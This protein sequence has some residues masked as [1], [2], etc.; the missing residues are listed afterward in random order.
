MDEN[1]KLPIKVVPPLETD[2]HVPPL[3]GGPKKIFVEDL[4]SLQKE[5]LNQLD[6]VN[7]FFVNSFKRKPKLPAVMKVRL[8]SDAAAKSHRPTKLFSNDSCPIIG[9]EGLGGLL[10]S[11][12][13]KSLE[14]LHQKVY[15]LDTK[16]LQANLSTIEQISPF[17]PDIMLE[18]G[19]TAIKVKLIRH[20]IK[21]FDHAIQEDFLQTI[22]E[23]GLRN[24]REVN[25]GPS[26]KIFKIFEPRQELLKELSG[27][28]GTQSLSG[29]PVYY[30]VRTQALPVGKI[31]AND[32]PIPDPLV[33]YPIVGV[34]DS[35]IQNTIEVLDPWVVGKE[36]Y[37]PD[38]Y[39]NYDH[40]TFVAGLI[41]HSQRLNHQDPRFPSCSAK[42]LDVAVMPKDGISEDELLTILEDVLPRHP[43][44]KFWNLSLGTNIPISQ[45]NFSDFAVGIDRLQREYGVT[46]ILAAGNHTKYLGRGITNDTLCA[47]ADSVRSI[48]VSAV[49]HTSH[50]SSL[51]ASEQPSPFS[52]KG[53]GP[54]YL[55]KPDISHYGGNCDAQGAYLQTGVISVN[56]HG[57]LAEDIGTSF[58]APLVSTLAANISNAIVGGASKNLTK[59]LLVHSAAMRSEINTPELLHTRGF[60]TPPDLDEILECKP[61]NCTMIFEI[62]VKPRIEYRKLQFPIAP[63]LYLSNGRMKADILMTLVYDPE[64]DASFGS[65]YCRTNI[66][67]SLGVIRKN[68]DGSFSHHKEV[69]EDPKLRG[70][71]YEKDLVKGGFKWSPVKVYRR[72]IARGIQ[73]DHWQLILNTMDRG[74]HHTLSPQDA[75]LI[76]TIADPDMRAPVY[77]ETVALMSR[78]GWGAQNLA[79][80]QRL[81]F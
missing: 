20:R 60:G 37:V 56:A 32:Y 43:E 57:L 25:Y 1:T 27:F 39:A 15:R 4:E 10:V 33:E 64:L 40:G 44:V 13:P 59:A 45:N 2:Y 12:T 46:F 9:S 65:E 17:K 66:E 53:P 78:L 54:V 69:P 3:G 72:K 7:Q 75:A 63:S 50:S 47:P 21:D 42:I 16:E 18:Q 49:A 52:R 41:V 71:A 77:N 8:R 81:R 68:K 55:P 19:L 70:S 73:A 61:W 36:N 35:G 24:I 79:V 5:L 29:F 11:I 80:M 74:E 34:V 28:V 51:S 23:F 76:I 30:P 48:V 31:G 38:G 22:Y 58:A 62:P 67:A 26:L 14:E 6:I